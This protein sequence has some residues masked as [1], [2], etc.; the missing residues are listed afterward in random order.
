MLCNQPLQNSP[1]IFRSFR[2]GFILS[3]AKEK[4]CSAKAVGPIDE[5]CAPATGFSRLRQGLLKNRNRARNLRPDLAPGIL[6]CP[7]GKSS[8]DRK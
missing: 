5:F 8:V 6:V 4:F 7:P 2:D 1:N 3:P